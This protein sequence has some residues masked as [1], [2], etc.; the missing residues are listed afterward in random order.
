VAEKILS[1][2]ELQIMRFEALVLLE[3]VTELV[4]EIGPRVEAVR[5]LLGDDEGEASGAGT[6]T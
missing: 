2:E 6:T 3:E 4:R 5:G 1:N